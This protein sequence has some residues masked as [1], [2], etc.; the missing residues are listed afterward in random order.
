NPLFICTRSKPS[1]GS[2]PAGL[3]LASEFGFCFQCKVRSSLVLRRPIETARETVQM[4]FAEFHWFDY[5]VHQDL[6]GVWPSQWE[7]LH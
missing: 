7:P 4:V 5:G 6:V 3:A 2:V 1:Q